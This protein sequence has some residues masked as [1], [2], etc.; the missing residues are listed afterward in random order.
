V[1]GV[2]LGLLDA[3]VG[4]GTVRNPSGDRKSILTPSACALRASEV[5]VRTTPLT[6]GCQAS[7]A[8]RTRI[9]PISADRVRSMCWRIACDNIAISYFN[10]MTSGASHGT[11]ASSIGRSPCVDRTPARLC[12]VTMLLQSNG[13]L[14]Q[15]LAS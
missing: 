8:T 1:D 9:K 6:C 14:P 11:P 10:R 7:V 13:R 3:A 2:G 4:T 5:K 15:R 12:R